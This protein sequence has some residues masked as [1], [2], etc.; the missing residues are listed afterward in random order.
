MVAPQNAAEYIGAYKI[1]HKIGEGGMALIY[2]AIQP[3]LKR[4]VVIKKLKD[5]NREIINRFKKE[6]LLSASFHHENLTAVY[7]FLYTKRSY[8]LVMEYVDGEDLR[9]IIDYMAPLPPALA[10]LLILEIVRGLQ[11]THARNII[12]RDIKPGNILVSYSGDVKLI[13]FGVA[14]DNASTRLTLTGMIVGTPA[15]MAPEQANGEPLSTGSDLFATGIL[16]YEL[17]TGVK[18][19]YGENNTEILS[20]IVRNKYIPPQRLNPDIPHAYR[21][22]IKKAIHKDKKHRYQNAAEMIKDLEK[23]IDW[24]A[25]SD[26]KTVISRFLKKLDKTQ[27]TSGTDSI[28]MQVFEAV[29]SWGWRTFRAALGFVIAGLLVFQGIRF[30]EKQLGYVQL[31]AHMQN[32]TIQVDEQN[33]QK[34]EKAGLQIGPLLKGAHRLKAYAPQKPGIVIADFTIKAHKTERINLRIPEVRDSASCAIISIP[35]G[36]QVVLNDST[37]G[38]TPLGDLHFL[39]GR[40]TI[41][42]SKA[43]YADRE[44]TIRLSRGQT[45][46]FRFHLFKKNRPPN[47]DRPIY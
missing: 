8:Y 28:K 19:F 1:L 29:P 5:P 18:P 23:A 38:R 10:G 46:T 11:Y 34:I 31:P 25:Q 27:E 21:T 42:L 16:L 43:G 20:K 35:A 3:S 12:H 24:Q 2:K 41:R 4:T 40:Y 13:D 6:A 44:E 45:Y 22:I 39:P 15:Y 26:K 14:K 37:Y 47:A 17:L 36:A 32:M 30:S 9:T 7:D 33:P